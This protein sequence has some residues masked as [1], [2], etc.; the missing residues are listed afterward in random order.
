MAISKKKGHSQR[1][2]FSAHHV[3]SGSALYNK[4]PLCADGRRVFVPVQGTLTH[5]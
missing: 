4:R 5:S 2:R 1:V 3:K